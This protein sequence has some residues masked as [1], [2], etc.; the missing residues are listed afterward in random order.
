MDFSGWVKQIS[1]SSPVYTTKLYVWGGKRPAKVRPQHASRLQQRTAQAPWRS[2]WAAQQQLLHDR[3]GFVFISLGKKR[4]CLF[5]FAGAT[6][7]LL[8]GPEDQSTVNYLLSNPLGR[9]TCGFLICNRSQFL[10]MCVCFVAAHILPYN[11]SSFTLCFRIHWNKHM[12]LRGFPPL[13][14][15]QELIHVQVSL[16]RSL[17][18]NNKLRI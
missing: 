12:D 10:Y 5:S 2:L 17:S 7:S 13:P 11:S 1:K 14:A 3:C 4:E 6:D 18:D 15:T 9:S 16:P 8:Q